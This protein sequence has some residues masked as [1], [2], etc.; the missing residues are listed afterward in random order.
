MPKGGVWR[1]VIEVAL[2]G[3]FVLSFTTWG[4]PTVVY[5]VATVY[6]VWKI[7]RVV[8]QRKPGAEQRT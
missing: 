7:V 6:C 3:V 8:R 4:V 1:V 5:L 2:F